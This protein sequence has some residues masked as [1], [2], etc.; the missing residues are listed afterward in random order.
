MRAASLTHYGFALVLTALFVQGFPVWQM[1]ALAFGRGGAGQVPFAA[2]AIAAAAVLVASRRAR[3]R[4][5][6][7]VLAATAVAI[8]AGLWLTD[9]AFPAKRIHVAEYMLLSVVV[10]RGASRHADGGALTVGTAVLTILFGIHDELAQGLHPSRTFGLTDVAVD[11]L[12]GLAGALAGHALGLFHGR[13]GAD[14][15]WPEPGPWLL[16]ASA[17]AIAL[18]LML[19]GIA[20]SIPASDSL[21]ALIPLPLWPVAPVPAAVAVALLLDP[22]RR[23]WL[24]HAGTVALWLSAATILYPVVAHAVPLAFR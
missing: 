17:V 20:A 1:L 8:V 22:P 23:A 24:R 6:W 4:R 13:P 18:V 3:S 16:S 15:G 21:A 7:L 10:R 2:A 9:P 11:A 19:A 14:C 5:R 12:G